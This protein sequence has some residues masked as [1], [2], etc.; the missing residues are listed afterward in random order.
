MSAKRPY[1]DAA[2]M[3]FLFEGYDLVAYEEIALPYYWLSLDVV[4]QKR[5]PVPGIDE[6]VLR[7]AQSGAGSLDEI[8][9]VLG[10]DLRL[11]QEAV[12]NQ[13]EAQT[14]S[15]D[16]GPEGRSLAITTRGVTA[17]NEL[18]TYEPATQE[19]NVLYDR[20]DGTL[21]ASADNLLKPINKTMRA[22]AASE[23]DRTPKPQDLSIDDLAAT[24]AKAAGGRVRRNALAD[25][26]LI[27]V[28]RVTRAE[29][30]YQPALLVIYRRRSK[31][32][33]IH[34]IIV[35]G[36]PSKRHII[37]TS[38]NTSDL[39]GRSFLEVDTAAFA[40][41]P[42]L[43]RARSEIPSRLRNS[44]ANG[45]EVD[46]DRRTVSKAI[47]EAGW[48]DAKRVAPGDE[49]PDPP[50]ARWLVRQLA[51][52]EQ[53]LLFDRAIETSRRLLVC[54]NRLR[55]G[56][57]SF[58]LLDDLEKVVRRG[59]EVHIYYGQSGDSHLDRDAMER[60]QNLEE[61]A[62]GRLILKRLKQPVH[63]AL[64]WDG[65][66]IAGA[67]PWLSH[68]GDTEAG[69]LSGEGLL[70]SESNAVEEAFNRITKLPI[71]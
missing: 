12:L 42:G 67:F 35:D 4:L 66:W 19:V 52:W 7:A 26:Q 16:V 27:A 50:A 44:I 63:N 69:P 58:Q 49:V 18:A 17:L 3:A 68:R 28:R 23:F 11:L 51:V 55:A 13:L 45:P 5:K 1:Q 36:M 37:K 33:Y 56:T 9:G 24:I 43:A 62:G 61:R 60:I 70:V 25:S 41:D 2:A 48:E 15:Y 57:V 34:G 29:R 8:G 20:V 65:S 40:S 30:R 14:V 46:V 21:I 71:A 31:R 59:V 22:I 10:L 39:E 53:P 6:F 38:I 32:T 54:A 64:I 47:G